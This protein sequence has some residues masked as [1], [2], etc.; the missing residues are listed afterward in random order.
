MSETFEPPKSFRHRRTRTTK[1]LVACLILAAIGAMIYLMTDSAGRDATPTV[2]HHTDGTFTLN[3]KDGRSITPDDVY[4]CLRTYERFGRVRLVS[5]P[6]TQLADWNPILDKGGAAGAADYQIEAGELWFSFMLPGCGNYSS[7]PLNLSV[8]IIHL[9]DV[10]NPPLDLEP[11]SDVVVLVN[12]TTTCA[13]ALKVTWEYE[14]KNESITIMSGE[15]SA[16]DVDDSSLVFLHQ[17][18]RHDRYPFGKFV[19]RRSDFWNKH[20]Q[21][22]IDRVTSV[23]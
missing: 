23:F 18:R 7:G 9:S 3:R 10:A 15:N 22:T 21:P 12:P 8:K 11:G 14:G 2:Y 13:E 17:R 1:A 16:Q 6:L 4:A 20:I 19:K 5:N